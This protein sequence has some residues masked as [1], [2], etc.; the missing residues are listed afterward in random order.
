MHSIEKAGVATIIHFTGDMTI[1]GANEAKAVVAAALTKS[2]SILIDV[3]QVRDAD[4]S[5]FQIICSAHRTARKKNK[6]MELMGAVQERLKQTL[7]ATG[8]YKVCTC[9]QST[10]QDCLWAKIGS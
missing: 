1:E 8:F 2:K 4:L 3:D 7:R 5:F 9:G 10:H 6:G